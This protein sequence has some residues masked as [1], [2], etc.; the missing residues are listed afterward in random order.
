LPSSAYI[1]VKDTTAP[2]LTQV[3]AVPTPTND[4]TPDYTFSSNEAGTIT[5]VGSCSSS[6]TS[7]IS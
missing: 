6:T 4:T 1:I 2:T 3:T 7:A 5:Y